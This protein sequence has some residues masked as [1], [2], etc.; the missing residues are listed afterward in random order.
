MDK[1]FDKNLLTDGVLVEILTD[2]GHKERGLKMSGAILFFD[3]HYCLYEIDDNG[4][5]KADNSKIIAVYE[6][7]KN[8]ICSD[9]FTMIDCDHVKTI[10]KRE[11]IELKIN[12]VMK[13]FNK[14]VKAEDIRKILRD[15]VYLK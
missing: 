1:K 6:I 4:I 10:W 7:E 3:K 11:M 13:Y 5:I 2:K 12:D 14:N 15:D 8:Y 9:I